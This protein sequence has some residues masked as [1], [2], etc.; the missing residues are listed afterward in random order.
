MRKVLRQLSICVAIVS[1]FAVVGGGC[2]SHSFTCEVQEDAYLKSEATCESAKTY[3]KSCECGEVGEETFSVGKKLRHDTDGQIESEEYLKTE[4][5]CLNPGLYYKF[6]SMCGTKSLLTFKGEKLG[7]H[8]YTEEVADGKYLKEEATRES[9]AVY[10]KSCVCGLTGEDTFVFGEKL[11]EYTA[12]EKVPYTPTSLTVTLY[13]TET[14]VYGFTYNTLAEPLRPVIQVAEGEEFTEYKEYSA[15]VEKATSYNTD[16]SQFA[17]YI[18]KAEVPLEAAKTY[19]Y[20]AYDKYVEV[21]TETATLK[22]K[23]LTTDTFSFAHVADTQD[24]PHAFKKVLQCVAGK[25]D[26]LLHTGDVVESSQHEN[27]WKA[28]LHGNFAYLS[29]IPMM[30]ISGNHETTYK[31]GSNETYKHFH[32]KMPKQE[33]KKGYYYSF[34]YGN[35]KF[36][37]LN[38]NV[39]Q[40]NGLAEAQYQWLVNE[41]SQNTATWTIVA[42]HNPMYSAGVYGSDPTRNDIAMALRG[43]LQGIF[44]E[45]GVDLVLQGHDH[46]ISRTHPID[47][48]GVVQT[49]TWETQGGID[50]SVDPNGVLYVMSG[51]AGGQT[52]GPNSNMDASLYNYAVASVTSS[53]T[54]F[55]IEGN[56]LTATVKC[57]ANGNEEVLRQWGVVK[58]AKA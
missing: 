58:S 12:E 2:H 31:H 1:A 3:Y 42:M 53:W 15:T 5:T 40:G 25:N 51:T 10:Y 50:Y 13:D 23:D 16:D 49:E 54:E 18:V 55:S 20:R 8:A 26:F 56:Q 9:A 27:E 6:C 24:Y 21:G 19:T 43:Q 22:T 48:D 38:T 29:Q 11:R 4:P 44:A 35:A 34:N 57:A 28:M 46:L 47:G 14:S 17:Y 41:L 45:Y 30:A 39:L 33:T 52:R 7:D 37:M 36:I 32:N